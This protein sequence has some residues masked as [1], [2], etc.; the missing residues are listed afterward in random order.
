MAFGFGIGDVV[1]AINALVTTCDKIAKVPKEMR[2]A[3]KDSQSLLV[4]IRRIGEETTD[5]S[6]IVHKE[7]RM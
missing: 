2:E 4:I 1:A 7:Q 6:S 5:K 3:A